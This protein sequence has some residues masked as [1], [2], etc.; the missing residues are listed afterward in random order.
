MKSASQPR[1][2]FSSAMRFS[3]ILLA[4]GALLLCLFCIQLFSGCGDDS[5]T[6]SPQTSPGGFSM[7]LI[8][9]PAG[10]W[11][12]PTVPADTTR[13][14]IFSLGTDDASPFTERPDPFDV[15]SDDVPFAT[16]T[17]VGDDAL[18]LDI[19]GQ[20]AD[21]WFRLFVELGDFRGVSTFKI[22]GDETEREVFVALAPFTATS[23]QLVIFDGLPISSLAPIVQT[24]FADVE[25]KALFMMF[26]IAL[27]NPEPI[28]SIDLIFG[29][30]NATSA[31]L[32]IDPGSR[33]FSA[34][35]EDA[36]TIDL[37]DTSHTS[38]NG[39]SYTVSIEPTAGLGSGKTIP[40][41][42]DILFYLLV[43]ADDLSS[44]VCL[45]QP[46]A[47][48]KK[49]GSDPFAPV[50]PQ[51][52]S[53][54][55]PVGLTIE[56]TSPTAADLI[57]AGSPATIAWTLATGWD[58]QMKLELLRDGS[59][60]G[61]PI[62][63]ATE[64]DARSFDWIA[65]PCGGSGG[66]Y[67]IQLT[68]LGET[69]VGGV[70]SAIS[71]SFAINS[72]CSLALTSPNGSE[73]YVTGEAVSILWDGTEC[74]GDSVAIVL[75]SCDDQCLAITDAT[76]NDGR[77]TWFAELCGGESC[78]YKIGIHSL[79]GALLDDSD[80]DFFIENACMIR[81]TSP[82][83]LA[84][85][86]TGKPQEIEWTFQDA[87]G[88]KVDIFLFRAGENCLQIASETENDGS[89]NWDVI[90]CDGATDNYRLRVID[91]ATD[92]TGVSEDQFQI[93]DACVPTVTSPDGGEVLTASTNYEIEWSTTGGCGASVRIDLYSEG[94]F[95]AT[96]AADT[97]NI[98]SFTWTVAQCSE[99]EAG[100]TIRITDLFTSASDDSNENFTIEPFLAPCAIS[101]TSPNGGEV[102][103]V[104][105]QTQIT[106]STEET[107]SDQVQIDL[108]RNGQ[109]CFT[110]NQ[111]A[112][113]SGTYDWIITQCDSETDLYQI[114]IT[115]P[116]GSVADTSDANFQITPAC[117]ITLTTPTAETTWCIGESGTIS[118]EVA[119]C[120][121]G[122]LSID[123][124]ENDILCTEIASVPVANGTYNWGVIP[125]QGESNYKIRIRE[126]NGTTEILSEA[127]AI[128]DTCVVA[129]TTLDTGG[130]FCEGDSL[131][132]SWTAGPCC[133][134]A[135][136]VAVHRDGSEVVVVS[137]SATSPGSVTWV[138]EQANG[139]A[140]GYTIVLTDLAEEVTTESA[141]TFTI[142]PPCALSLTYPDSGDEVCEGETIAITWEASD[143]C[144]SSLALELTNSTSGDCAVIG[145]ATTATG[146]YDWV[147]AGCDGGE[148]SGYQIKA[149]SLDGQGAPQIT[150]SSEG[151]FSI[152][153]ECDL[154]ISNPVGGETFDV[155]DTLAIAWSKS[156]C[157]GNQ[158]TLDLVDTAT[159]E[160]LVISSSATSK[161]AFNWIVEQIDVTIDTYL[162]EL[163]DLDTEAT[164][165]SGTFSIVHPCL[166]ELQ[167]A[168]ADANLCVDE[169]VLLEWEATDCVE[170]NAVIELLLDGGASRETIAT[171]TAGSEEYSW[172]PT[173]IDEA[174]GDYSISIEPA[175][176]GVGD[177]SEGT[178][179]ITDGCAL[180][181]TYPTD[182]THICEDEEITIRWTRGSCCGTHVAIDLYQN[183]SLCEA[184]ATSVA[185]ADSF[186]WTV[187]PCSEVL[188]GY[189]IRIS[190]TSTLATSQSAVP[191][192]VVSGGEI[193]SPNATS[194]FTE[195][196]D[197]PINWSAPCTDNPIAIE[198]W[199]Y[200]YS[201]AF[202]CAFITTSTPNTGTYFWPIEKCPEIDTNYFVI[203]LDAVSGTELARSN[204][205]FTINEYGRIWYVYAD[206]S[207]AVATIQDA[208]DLSA[209]GDIVRL[210]DGWFTGVGNRDL[211]FS[212]KAITLESAD[213]DPRYC[214][215]DCESATRAIS[216]INGE[217]ASSV[218]QYIW[219][220]NGFA[221]GF[222]GDSGNGGG[223]YCSGSSP[224]ITNCIIDFCRTSTYGGA[225]YCINSSPTITSSTFHRNE[226]GW[227]TSVFSAVSGVVEVTNCIL[228]EGDG[229]GAASDDASGSVLTACCCIFAGGFK[230][231]PVSRR[232][233]GD[234]FS[235]P[236]FCWPG[237]GSNGYR[238]NYSSPCSAAN[239]PVC[240]QMGALGDGCPGK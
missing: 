234:I 139:A 108:L 52:S 69:G 59:V 161:G 184:I 32:Y 118:W 136:E 192:T 223:I 76:L 77:F 117:V 85:L 197:M 152:S 51:S 83:P 38:P 110:I 147:V 91:I 124:L 98:G 194:V 35:E 26:P 99:A 113:N 189:K 159:G 101:V 94:E 185:D 55:F 102:L 123:L 23:N 238:L 53:C 43:T 215:I 150:V 157:C 190:D 112:P 107:C 50:I 122:T 100:Y 155:G 47:Q 178:F 219:I 49:P 200:T 7:S 79:S 39:D 21:T 60:C 29:L 198:L 180:T 95:C 175:Q 70:A 210:A 182:E 195:S 86:V 5:N 72:G 58:S 61:N 105:Q 36:F 186:L 109:S 231:A 216:F 237:D 224:T 149:T 2:G 48:F 45:D 206:G 240:G 96:L 151:H 172:S 205:T 28:E 56:V 138:A 217:S 116:V 13:A 130:D 129:L 93:L 87:C 111:A 166:I 146:S 90:Q 160:R 131:T 64:S 199:N 220:T 27:E 12:D 225:V 37:L 177:Q 14:W 1:H 80:D 17:S 42:N 154:T 171:V 163:T 63:A 120:N 191:F 8:M 207:G 10:V 34:G 203:I 153:T 106:W 121:A 75:Y 176:P 125:C 232:G 62:S 204:G 170:L 40:A 9:P 126:D 46:S 78:N 128:T 228:S 158:V 18:E 162:I 202:P 6:V 173:Q 214:I 236:E 20:L 15:N 92:A 169:S 208:I 68:P 148:A 230:A 142:N 30:D 201:D 221:G 209:D 115:D 213:T 188:S 88:D 22:D 179:S 143:C 181:L 229:T 233:L 144:G 156:S 65:T 82:A 165:T 33:L 54:A 4:A 134:D 222:A 141:A 168:L 114:A 137:E 135:V 145:Q 183:G 73:S 226:A 119:N 196:Q 57:C 132:I 235:D 74:C 24:A 97:P 212:G 31:E 84:S 44:T 140:D 81:I 164:A 16:G 103:S 66:S 218:V 19:T 211:D 187:T 3:S 193:Y 11:P 41:G 104:D 67:Q 227:G 239:Q 174:T 167:T 71:E 25:E 127:F 89:Y 133:G